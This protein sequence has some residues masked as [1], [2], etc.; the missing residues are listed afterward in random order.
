[1]QA[2]KGISALEKMLLE[3]GTWLVNMSASATKNLELSA[4]M[5]LLLLVTILT[6]ESRFFQN[7][8]SEIPGKMKGAIS[9]P[10]LSAKR[11][12]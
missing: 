9:L 8:L 11:V 12:Q 4:I 6:M 7:S 3:S 5:S 2:L 10:N 1:M